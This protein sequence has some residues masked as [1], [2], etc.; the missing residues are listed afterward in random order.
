MMY[1]KFDLGSNILYGVMGKLM[2]IK[3]RRDKALEAEAP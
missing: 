1:R 3:R 2:V